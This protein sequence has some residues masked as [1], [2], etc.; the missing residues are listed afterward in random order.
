MWSA[1]NDF[2]AW[3]GA[4]PFALW[5]GASTYR[6]A[7]LFA[8]HV[9]GLVLLL[10]GVL[11]LSLRMLNMVLPRTPVRAVAKSA[12]PVST[13]GLLVMLVS[14][15][16]IFSGGAVAYSEGQPFRIKMVLLAVAILFHFFVFRRAAMAAEE[17]AQTFSRAAVG[18]GAI[19]LWFSVAWV[20]RA[21][22]FF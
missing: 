7:A 3:L 5:V 21:I 22:A 18:A 4:T 1:L 2:V 20:G 9:C 12:L 13:I 15:V 10:G 16:I 17:Q 19:L 11:F 14:G 6:I 8:A